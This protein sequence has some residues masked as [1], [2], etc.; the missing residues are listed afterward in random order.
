MRPAA[1]LVNGQGARPMRTAATL[2][3]AEGAFA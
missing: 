1:R 3:K 2:V